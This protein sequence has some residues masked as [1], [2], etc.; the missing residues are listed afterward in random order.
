MNNKL[1]DVYDE[2]LNMNLKDSGFKK[3]NNRLYKNSKEDYITILHDLGHNIYVESGFDNIIEKRY[4]MDDA[5][6]S[7]ILNRFSIGETRIIKTLPLH[8]G[9]G[10]SIDQRVRVNKL[11]D[12]YVTPLEL[13]KFES[14]NIR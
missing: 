6:L 3:V 7:F 1:I 8:N 4:F 11:G 9:K 10:Y 13:F 2:I 12:M 5:E 14:R